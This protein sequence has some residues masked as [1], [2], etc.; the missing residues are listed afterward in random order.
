MKK[1]IRTSVWKKL[2][3][4]FFSGLIVL[5][6]IVATIYL[7]WLLFSK[8]D[9]LLKG[10]FYKWGSSVGLQPF[11]GLGFLTIIVIILLVGIFVSNYV[12]KK[13]LQMFDRLFTRLPLVNGVYSTIQ[14]ISQAFLSGEKAVLKQAVLFEYPRKGMYSIGFITSESWMEAERKT[15]KRTVNIFLPTT[16]NPTSGYLLL[17]PKDDIIPLQISVEEALKLIVSGGSVL[18]PDQMREV[19]LEKTKYGTESP[20]GTAREH[21]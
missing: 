14:R 18:P 1:K 9:G 4:W 6:P 7:L 2:R 16:P 10:V 19:Q 13:L 11:P 5:I 12:G 3:I 15:G 17:I 21:T 20:A 8:I